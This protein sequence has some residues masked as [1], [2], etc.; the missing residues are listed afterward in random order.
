MNNE[1]TETMIVLSE[2]AIQQKIF[3]VRGMKVM[4]DYD[5]AK[6]Y[7][8]ETKNLKRQVRRNMSRFPPD[9]MFELTEMEN[10]SLRCQNVTTSSH[11]G[12]RY[13]PFAFTELGVAML[14]SVLTSEIAVQVNISIMR[15]FAAM[16][17]FISK[18][19]YLDVEIESLKAKLNLLTEQREYDL[20]SMNNLSEEIRT[21]MEIINQ[22]IAELSN[23]IE[24]KNLSPRTPI[25][26]KRQDESPG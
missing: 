15:A 24:E 18:Q 17:A 1:N 11:G 26:F 10:N 7:Q 22:A 25:G 13:L 19:S 5:L 16:K 4:L 21:E 14:S 9:F 8:I 12:N 23:K 20:E 6:L 2:T 3:E